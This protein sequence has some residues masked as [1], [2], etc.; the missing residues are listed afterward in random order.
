MESR[1]YLDHEH[2]PECI[3]TAEEMPPAGNPWVLQW[4]KEL[5]ELLHVRHEKLA[6]TNSLLKG[7]ILRQ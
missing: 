7:K 2:C 4:Q 3:E 1:E 5:V 6:L